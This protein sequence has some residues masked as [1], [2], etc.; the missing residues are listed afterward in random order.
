M[1]G[2]G[3]FSRLFERRAQLGVVRAQRLHIGC[4][5]VLRQKG[6]R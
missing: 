2:V 1:K 6:V 4:H 3:V 5:A